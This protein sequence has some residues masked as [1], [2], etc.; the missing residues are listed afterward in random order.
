MLVVEGVVARVDIIVA[1]R[2]LPRVRR[3]HARA[4]P[5]VVRALQHVDRL[6]VVGGLVQLEEAHPVFAVRFTHLLDAVAPRRRE[7]VHQP[8]VARDVRDAQ[9]P[10]GVVDAVDADGREADGGVDLVAEQRGGAVAHVRVAQHA[11]DDLVAVEGGAVR[12]VR[13]ADARVAG[14]VQPAALA[15]AFLGPLLQLVR[16]GVER[17]GGPAAFIGGPEHFALEEA[18]LRRA[19]VGDVGIVWVGHYYWDKRL[20]KSFGGDFRVGKKREKG[21]ELGEVGGSQKKS[22]GRA[23]VI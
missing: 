8:Q 1:P 21:H 14:G 15:E 18:P 16:V 23:Q 7:G 3:E 20:E 13:P 9:F 12:R 19:A 6:L 2:Q 17:A 10:G 4:E 5:A 22:S 11:R